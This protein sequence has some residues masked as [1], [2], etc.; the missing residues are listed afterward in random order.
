MT[1]CYS[2]PCTQIHHFSAVEFLFS[3]CYYIKKNCNRTKS[4]SGNKGTEAKC[5]ARSQEV[6]SDGAGI[7]LKG[8]HVQM[9]DERAFS[10]TLIGQHAFLHSPA[11]NGFADYLLSVCCT[12]FYLHKSAH[13]DITGQL[14]GTICVFLLCRSWRLS[15]GHQAL[16][17]VSFPLSHLTGPA[18]CCMRDSD[19]WKLC[20]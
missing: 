20:L 19:G 6:H 2:V 12:F 5:A 9:I 17:P 18:L 3:H 16:Q 13:V 8:Q 11:L 1:V 10:Y 15:S 4:S 7:Q 14:K